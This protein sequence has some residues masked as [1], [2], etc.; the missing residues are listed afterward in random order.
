MT[1]LE[2]INWIR[3]EHPC[4]LTTSAR[5]NQC[6]LRLANFTGDSLAIIN[7]TKYQSNHGERI[8]GKLADR[9][10]FSARD[11]GFVCVTELKGGSWRARDTIEQVKNGFVVAAELLRGIRVN[12]WFPLVLSGSGPRPI[13]ERVL[14]RDLIP[15]QGQRLRL[16]HFHCNT[17]LSQIAG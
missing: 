9:I 6:S 12:S 10:I 7:G 4:C 17:E 5:E 8:S 1:L 13:D 3:Q 16:R 11:G 2:F 14:Q 15:F